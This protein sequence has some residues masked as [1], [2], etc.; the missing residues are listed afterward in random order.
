[1]EYLQ[2]SFGHSQL[3]AAQ[4]GREICLLHD[5]LG[6]AGV[7]VAGAYRSNSSKLTAGS[8]VPPAPPP[9]VSVD[10]AT[11]GAY[12]DDD[13]KVTPKPVRSPPPHSSQ[14]KRVKLEVAADE[15]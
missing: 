10:I 15:T 5:I 8:A 1:M 4:M 2:Q 11:G 9:P 13:S 12:R 14:I 3:A 6:K 7:D